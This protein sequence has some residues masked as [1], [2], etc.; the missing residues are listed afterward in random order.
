MQGGNSDEELLEYHHY[1]CRVLIGQYSYK[2]FEYNGRVQ[3]DSAKLPYC[4]QG[5][6]FAPHDSRYSIAFKDMLDGSIA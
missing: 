3:F 1:G 2:N 6:Y 4:G 5:G